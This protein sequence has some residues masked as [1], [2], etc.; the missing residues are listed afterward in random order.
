MGEISHTKKAHKVQDKVVVV[1][2]FLLSFFMQERI[3]VLFSSLLFFYPPT[4]CL[5]PPDALVLL[6]GFKWL[7][8]LTF[9]TMFIIID[10]FTIFDHLSY[11]K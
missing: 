1:D 5:F 11:L 7:S 9:F 10:F 8:S 6:C 4:T 2:F 3:K